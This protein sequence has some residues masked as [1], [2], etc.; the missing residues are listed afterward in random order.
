MEVES[1]L[2]NRIR[3]KAAREEVRVFATF[4]YNATLIQN[5]STRIIT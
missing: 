1:R 5:E 4:N 2:I 3:F